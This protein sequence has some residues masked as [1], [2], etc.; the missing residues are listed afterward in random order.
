[1]EKEKSWWKMAQIYSLMCDFMP[2][3]VN[4]NVYLHWFEGE[5]SLMYGKFAWKQIRRG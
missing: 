3:E 1:M 4:P 2:P 5:F